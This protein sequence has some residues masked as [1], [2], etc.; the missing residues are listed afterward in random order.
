MDTSA[1]NEAVMLEGSLQI[2]DVDAARE[3][4]TRLLDDN[5][6][7]AIDLAGLKAVDT[8]GIQLL[9]AVKIEAA[10]RGAPIEYRGRSPLLDQALELLGLREAIFGGA[11]A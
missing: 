4:F 3:R 11:A 6:P 8:A 2:Q 10:R 5:V 9:L 7:R 1:V